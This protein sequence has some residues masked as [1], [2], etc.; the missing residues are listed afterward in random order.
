MFGSR[1]RAF[2]LAGMAGVGKLFSGG[3]GRTAAGAAWGGAYGAM[4]SDTSVL[5]GALMGAG[6]SR[7]GGAGLKMANRG[8]GGLGF[9]AHAKMATMGFGRGVYGQARRDYRGAALLSNN[10]GNRIKGLW[11]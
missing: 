3:L 1:F 5:G 7:Y 8:G 6:V 11:K 9:R 2:G 4:S 10:I